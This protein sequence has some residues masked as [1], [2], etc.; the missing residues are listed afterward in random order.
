MISIINNNPKKTS[1]PVGFQ[2]SAAFPFEK[3]SLGLNTGGDNDYNCTY[4][5]HK[6][7]Y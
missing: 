5:I 2:Q 7:I 1:P 4:G 6:R 3:A